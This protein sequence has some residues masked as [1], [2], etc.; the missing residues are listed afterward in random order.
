MITKDPSGNGT[1]TSAASGSGSAQNKPGL[2]STAARRECASNLSTTLTNN[3]EGEPQKFTCKLCDLYPDRDICDVLFDVPAK[4]KGNAGKSCPLLFIF[5]GRNGNNDNTGKLHGPNLHGTSRSSNFIGVYPQGSKQYDA[6]DIGWNTGTQL[7]KPNDTSFVNSIIGQFREHFGWD[8]RVYAY[9]HSNG[10]ALT[11]QLAV[12]GAIGLS[13]AATSATQLLQ[14]PTTSGPGPYNYNQPKK[15]DG[16]CT[17]RIAILSLAGGKDSM[18]PYE[19]GK[20]FGSD[21]NILESVEKSNEMWAAIN[22]CS[23]ITN[24]TKTTKAACPDS[25]AACS[26]TGA[27]HREWTGCA[28]TAPIEAWKVI[29]GGHG[30]AKTFGSSAKTAS[31][32][33][34][35]FFTKVETE[36]KKTG[37][38]C[39]PSQT[40]DTCKALA[41]AARAPGVGNLNTTNVDVAHPLQNVS[42]MTITLLL[43]SVFYLLLA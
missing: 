4:C 32:L 10:S 42:Q 13:G 34:F 41:T 37:A 6:D 5:H 2:P 33:V 25:N 38:Q 14:S 21:T 27:E 39:P 20:L 17:E 29:D 28:S 12:N 43:L 15:G 22:G 8:S 36:C 11:Q 3:I 31:D 30:V 24:P 19:G 9:G 40:T 7:S 23:D 26:A 1:C 35:D 18:I 16:P